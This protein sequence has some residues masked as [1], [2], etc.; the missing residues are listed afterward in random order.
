MSKLMKIMSEII[1]ETH[2]QSRGSDNELA[3]AAPVVPYW[4]SAIAHYGHVN[5]IIPIEQARLD[6][7]LP[8]AHQFEVGELGYDGRKRRYLGCSDN[9]A[10]V[11]DGFIK[12]LSRVGGPYLCS[13][14]VQTFPEYR[15][16]DFT[17]RTWA[18][19]RIMIRVREILEKHH[20]TTTC[21]PTFVG[22]QSVFNSEPDP[23]FTFLVY[24]DNA[25]HAALD[26]VKEI[27]DYLNSEGVR[28]F[29]VEICHPRCE[30][31]RKTF[32]ISGLDRITKCW[33]DVLDAIISSVDLADV[34]VIGCYRR[35]RSSAVENTLPT[36]LV[37]VES[38]STRRN[39]KETREVIV[40]ILLHFNLLDVA[41]EIVKDEL[42]SDPSF[43]G[44]LNPVVLSGTAKIGESIAPGSDDS[45]SWTL[46]GFIELQS[47]VTQEWHV[48]GLT[49]FH[50]VVPDPDTVV[51]AASSF[52][53][54]KLL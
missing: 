29:S 10:K 37:I 38:T 19:S 13:I 3:Y 6:E 45:G 54:S 50:C 51:G 33:E 15:P 27:Y 4:K 9:S 12:E 20:I 22:R 36:V 48:F 16:D 42:R 7:G 8:P 25:G 32:P 28:N 49:C 35:G 46:G 5:N 39:W 18:K 44:T 34:I 43:T 11:V 14:P 40:G 26:A 53:N 47:P 41:V 24:S 31:P 1:S 30:K 23:V 17:S 2:N 52:L 21:E